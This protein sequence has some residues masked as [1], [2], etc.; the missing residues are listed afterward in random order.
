MT[1]HVAVVGDSLAYGAGD[2][3]RK[4][5]AGRLQPELAALG[6]DDVQVINYGM[7]GAR[8]SDVAARLH[9]EQLRS[10]LSRADAIVLSIGANDL[11]EHRDAREEILRAPLAVAERILTRVQAVVD[12]I[13]R[14]APSALILLLGGYNPL[15]GHP[16][17]F[18]IDRYLDLWDQRLKTQFSR[19]PR[20][21]VVRLSDII[22]GAEMLS[23]IDHF[24][25]GGRA[26][27]EAAK[28][29]AAMLAGEA[30]EESR[31]TGARS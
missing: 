28:R 27:A 3:A 14:V 22:H 15:P 18:M 17:S 8:T 6:F 16:L 10:A 31:R 25:P 4:G 26:Y 29:I 5:I 24:H 20:I 7:N 19:Y 2:E 23:R 9:Q 21:E 1:L 12:E 30:R 13:R 11:L